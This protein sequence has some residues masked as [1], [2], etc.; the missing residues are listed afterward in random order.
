MQRKVS[1]HYIFPGG[2]SPIKRGIVVVDENGEITDLIDNGGNLPESEK[3]E[4][5]DGIIT[6][7]FINTHTHL[8][9]SH[10][11]G[12]IDRQTGLVGFIRNIGQLRNHFDQN[13]SI[14]D[15]DLLMQEN[16]IVAAGDISNTDTSFSVKAK[17][18]I[19]YYTFIEIFGIQDNIAEERLDF[20]IELLE[21]LKTF[22]LP[23]SV[24]PHAP[25]SMSG[26]LWKLLSDFSIEHKLNWSVHNQESNEENLLFLDKTGKIAEFLA[27][28]S[29]EFANWE[30]KGLSSLQYCRGFYQNIPRLLLVHNTFTSTADLVSIADL[31]EKTTIVLCPNANLYIENRLPDIEMLS[32]SCFPISLGTDSLA[33][34]STLSILEEMKTIQQHY[35]TISLTDL[36]NW[37]T[38]NG[39]NALGFEDR[40][41]SIEKGKK[42]GLNL[43]T[44]VN[45]REMKLTS[46]SEVK[47]LV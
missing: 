27:S 32:K 24:T 25:Y 10:L 22:H 47:V 4:F 44:N 18:K 13:K 45:F 35:P 26:L 36:I 1:A 14:I 9:L 3:L 15:A 39:A 11:K 38:I 2:R 41:G 37:G 21:K 28:I 7:G 43:I 46:Q 31:H 16:G 5:Y 20:G 6:A 12:E 40:L 17:S 23:G 42:P 30:E 33:S 19:D 8:E 34:N 29:G